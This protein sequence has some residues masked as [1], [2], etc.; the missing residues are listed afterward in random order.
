[1]GRSIGRGLEA[2]AASLMAVADPG[3]VYARSERE[4]IG[5]WA[6]RVTAANSKSK[7]D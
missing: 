6:A 1:M 2:M 4:A 7:P 3:G 5:R